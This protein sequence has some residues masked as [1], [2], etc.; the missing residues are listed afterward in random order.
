M[1][2]KTFKP[3]SAGRRHMTVL[4]YANVVTRDRPEKKLTV[5]KLRINGRNNQG[6]VTVR[7]R[8]GGNKRRLRLID[9]RR[10]KREV[11]ARVAT[12]E[13][14]PNRTSLIAL[15]HYKD[16][17]KRYI[18]CPLDLKVGDSVVASETA[19][20]RPGNHLPLRA[21]PLG[22]WIH[23][24]EV[25]LGKGGQLV[26]SAGSFA[27]VMAKEGRYV[28]LRMPS[29]EIRQVLCDCWA[30]VGQVGNLD[31]ENLS[32][33][34]AGRSRWRG[35]RPT[36]RGVAQNP[37]DHP[38]GGGEGRSPQGNPHPVTP[39]GKPTKGY[40]TRNQRRTDRWIVRRRK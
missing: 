19:D 25:K 10:D 38:H 11:P 32:I 7:H 28:Q 21:I 17:E 23:N 9:F 16:G 12:I 20:I 6:R 39:W 30:T 13:Y 40:K 31:H 18:L 2:V 36:V 37:V 34:K 35:I 33:G 22:T 5:R 29:G 1:S 15:L 3:T 27:Q 26:R 4:E 8:G 14:D 24:V